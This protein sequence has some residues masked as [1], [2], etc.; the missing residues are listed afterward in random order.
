[1]ATSSMTILDDLFL[2]TLKDIYCAEKWILKT[3]SNMARATYSD[4]GKAGFL[5]HRNEIRGQIQRL[6]QV[7]GLLGKPA[8]GR[9]FVAIQAIICEGGEIMEGFN[10]SPARDARLISSAQSVEHYDIAR[11]GM[12]ITGAN[13]LGL[14]G[15]ARLLHA[16]LKEE[17]ALDVKLTKLAD[18]PANA[19]DNDP[20]AA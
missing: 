4:E 3:L 7:F 16:N 15:A 5:P 10:R 14:T 1:M 20:T 8:R 17:D 2:D 18:A 12:L 19:N 9:T 6:K 13:P 11:H